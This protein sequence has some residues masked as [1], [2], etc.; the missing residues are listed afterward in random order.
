[1]DDVRTGVTNPVG[2]AYAT[3]KAI[4]IAVAVMAFVQPIIA[5]IE[6]AA[7]MTEPERAAKRGEATRLRWDA[8]DVVRYGL[9]KVAIGDG[10]KRASGLNAGCIVEV[11]AIDGFTAA[12]AGQ[13]GT[14]WPV[15]CAVLLDETQWTRV[16][17]VARTAL[18]RAAENPA[19]HKAI[20]A[21][22]VS[23]AGGYEL[24]DGITRGQTEP[25][26]VA[27]EDIG[28]EPDLHT[29]AGE[30]GAPIV[31]DAAQALADMTAQRDAW[32]AS[33]TSAAKELREVAQEFAA[34]ETAWNAL[35]GGYFTPE[36]PR[37]NLN[38]AI[39]ALRRR[40]VSW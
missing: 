31:S 13:G 36:G 26:I 33:A 11:T 7:L 21:P 28:H 25:F 14:S 24:P 17:I 18:D 5:A 16:D 6:H 19:L 4:K 22:A 40:V 10:F 9:M 38:D 29:A 1:M 3:A 30:A 2:H 34:I 8:A 39:G 37:L 32:E 15:P 12:V 20:A 35:A 27:P 23:K